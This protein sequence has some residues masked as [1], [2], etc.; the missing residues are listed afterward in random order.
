[1]CG[2]NPDGVADDHILLGRVTADDGQVLGIIVNY[3][4]HP[5][6]LAWENTLISPDY[7]GS[8]REIIEAQ[9]KAPC[10]FLQGA[11]GDV[12]P[13]EGFVGDV[14]VA[15][16]N[17][18]ELGFAVLSTLESLP[19]QGT[20]FEYAGAIVSGATLGVWKHRPISSA[21]RSRHSKWAREQIK[22]DLPY[23]DDLPDRGEL[24]KQL[25]HWQAEETSAR[26][27]GHE[28]KA[29]D[30]RAIQERQARRLTRI[31]GL[32]E[33]AS[34][35]LAVN[36]WQL[37]DALWLAVE[38]EHYNLLQRAIRTRFPSYPIIVAT[39]AGGS[40]CWYLPTADAFGK[41][42]YQEAASVLQQG[43]LETLIDAITLNIQSILDV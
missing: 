9:T 38:G 3:A 39:L 1:M 13:R 11:S 8:M 19:P 30:A 27:Q 40:R 37:G 26:N 24:R 6:T 14:E 43:S 29:R 2:F 7:V 33:G 4:C 18:R 15:D 12:G 32:P 42:L 35:P 22:V 5:T 10:L 20:D 28:T 25:E 16:K 41:G 23:R 31:D 34:F 36:I 17:G 21:H